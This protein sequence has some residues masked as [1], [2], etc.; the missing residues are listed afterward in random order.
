MR[1]NPDNHPK[2]KEEYLL[3]LQSM[4]VEDLRKET[5]QKIW[6]SAF[7][8]NNPRACYHWQCDYTYDEWNRRG[9]LQEYGGCYDRVRRSEVG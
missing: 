9:M 1:E 4:S 5:E 7:A 3:R 6:L 2:K 8:N